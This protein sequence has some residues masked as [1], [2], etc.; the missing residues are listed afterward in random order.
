MGKGAMPRVLVGDFGEGNVEGSGKVGTGTIEVYLKLYPTHI[1]IL[2]RNL[3]DVVLLL[4]WLIVGVRNSRALST[5]A[6]MFSLGM[7]IHFM[8]FKGKLPY[9]ANGETLE[10]LEDLRR[11]VQAFAG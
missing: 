10:S 11:E 6:D 4:R 2:H 1:S 7:V 8:A 3:L 5:K 9:S